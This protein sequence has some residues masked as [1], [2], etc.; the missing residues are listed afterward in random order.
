M[1]I[2]RG[3]LISGGLM[4]GG[5]LSGGL[6]SYDPSVPTHPIVFPSSCSTWRLAP[7]SPTTCHFLSHPPHPHT[8]HP[9]LILSTPLNPRNPTP[10]L[11]SIVATCCSCSDSGEK[12]MSK[13]NL[14]VIALRLL[15]SA[16]IWVRTAGAL[17][18]SHTHGSLTDLTA[19]TRIWVRTAGTL[20]G[21]HTHTDHSRIS[22]QT[23]GSE[24]G[25]RARCLDHTH[26]RITHG[27]H[28]RHTDLSEDGG[29]AAWITHTRITHGSHRRHTDLSE[30]GGHAAW[31]THTHGSLTDLITDT[32]IWVRT[33]GAL[34]GSH[35]HTDHSR[36][37]PQTHGSEWGRRARCLD[38]T[39]TDHSRISPQTHG[40][41]WGRRTLLDHTLTR[42][43]HGSHRRHTDLSEDGGRAAWITHTHTDHSRISPDTRIRVRTAGTLPGSHIH[44]RIT[45][46]SHHRHTDLSEDGGRAAWITHTHGS[47]TDLTADTRIW[48]KTA[49]AL[50]GSHT[51]GSLTDL[52]TDT[53]IWVRTAGALP[54]SHTHTDHS[55]ISPQTHGSEWRRRARCL[56]HTYT[57]DH[58]R[59]SPQ[60]QG[61]EW[62]RRA[63]CLD[64]THTDRSRISPQTHGSEWG[65]RAR[66]LDHT[67]T[68]I[69][70]GSHHRH[71]DLSEDGG[72]AAWIT[73]TH[74]SLTDL[75]ADSRIWVRTAGAL[76]GSHTH[77]SLADLTADTRI[78]AGTV[79]VLPGS[80]RIGAAFPRTTSKPTTS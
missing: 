37:S 11:T 16:T 71:T 19:D 73:H 54:G 9:P 53:R 20:P 6:K 28:R 7:S 38:H 58:S 8:R 50:P 25:R 80:H 68:R 17:P 33:A 47:L 14:C 79:S 41:E 22:P 45:H 57:P 36:I 48:V 56:D 10:L 23:H 27:S 24:W 78:A 66:C 72:R 42:I 49:G 30:D 32:R 4:S 1:R 77:G 70:H 59:I 62:G 26:T 52:T 39:H 46:G 64:H 51:H 75:T 31:I 5:R 60:T 2:N 35:T 76:P 43:A 74:G 40:S 18:G 63:H 44:T 65:R 15:I 3:G 61:S 34:P 13:A 29:R 21:S 55:R 67:H 12:T 69:T